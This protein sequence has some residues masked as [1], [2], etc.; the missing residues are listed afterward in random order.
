MIRMGITKKDDHAALRE[1]HLEMMPKAPEIPCSKCPVDFDTF[2]CN[3][4]NLFAL[5]PSIHV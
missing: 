5:L 4:S 1:K 2:S 3:S